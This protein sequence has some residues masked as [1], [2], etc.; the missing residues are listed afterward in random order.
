MTRKIEHIP[1]FFK[2][3]FLLLTVYFQC[4]A[5]KKNFRQHTHTQISVIISRSCPI[6]SKYV[7]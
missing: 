2:K 1:L 4:E 7:M 3:F 6:N 5:T